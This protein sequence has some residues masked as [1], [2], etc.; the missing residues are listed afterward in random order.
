MGGT[1]DLASAQPHS[2]AEGTD[3]SR[4]A[5]KRWRGLRARGSCRSDFPS[6][7]QDLCEVLDPRVRPQSL[8]RQRRGR[9]V[10]SRGPV[11]QIHRRLADQ[12]QVLGSVLAADA[13]VVFAERHV[14]HPVQVVLDLPVSAN[15]SREHLCVRNHARDVRA[16]FGA[17]RL[18]RRALRFD[19]DDA[20]KVGPAVR[21]RQPLHILKNPNPT[22]LE[23][24]VTLV[25]LLCVAR[26]RLLQTPAGPLVERVHDL[27]V[28]RR[29]VALQSEQV[30]R[31]P[32]SDR[33]RNASL[34]PHRVDAHHRPAQVQQLQQLGD[35]SD[36]VALDVGGK[37]PE[38]QLVVLHPRVDQV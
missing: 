35:R 8:L 7:A 21:L 38:R 30:V 3:A 9:P 36:L 19:H 28:Q 5:A 27:L 32:V 1:R 34:A 13:R 23:P 24:T 29:L 16:P 2:V 25:S 14:Q 11:Q 4:D 12:C 6:A 10:R 15:Q 22:N 31:S 20:A 33:F 26:R 17:R 37:L 18:A